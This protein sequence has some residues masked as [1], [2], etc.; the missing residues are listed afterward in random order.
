MFGG[1]CKS[2]ENPWRRQG[3]AGPPRGEAKT[4]VIAGLLS[5]SPLVGEGK[6]GGRFGLVE[7]CL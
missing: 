1:A 5:A 3:F 4:G 6:G 7:G 2:L